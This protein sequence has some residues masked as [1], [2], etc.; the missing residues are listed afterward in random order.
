M[1]RK[2]I[3]IL[4]ACVFVLVFGLS[5]YAFKIANSRD[6]EQA[7]PDTSI[8]ADPSEKTPEASGE[9][10]QTGE[11]KNQAETPVSP[12]PG[13]DTEE[14][15]SENPAL[16]PES[17]EGDDPS[18]GI[19]EI[20]PAASDD[21]EQTTEQGTREETPDAA[22]WDA[23][24]DLL[25]DEIPAL[26]PEGD[27]DDDYSS[28][29]NQENEGQAPASSGSQENKAP[30]SAGT[31]SQ[32]KRTGNSADPGVPAPSTTPDPTVSET[33]DPSVEPSKEGGQ[34][35]VEENETSMMT[36]F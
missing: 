4:I 2:K 7:K 15:E 27:E 35:Q 22:D 10:G 8:T 23:D 21:E 9:S 18:A 25:E 1:K 28:V 6:T 24:T 32:E 5:I 20:P 36:D 30:S 12:D 34:G 17:G 11:Q 31:S 29:G 13:T 3:L 16:T 19:Q 33:P 14:P 26:P